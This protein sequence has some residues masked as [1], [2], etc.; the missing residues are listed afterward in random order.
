MEL[1]GEGGRVRVHG[2]RIHTFLS[3]FLVADTQKDANSQGSISLVKGE[4][5]DKKNEQHEDRKQ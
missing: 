1:V 3:A 5:R 4:V 2:V